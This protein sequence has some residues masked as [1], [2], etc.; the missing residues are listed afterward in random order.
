MAIFI[1]DA[2]TYV[3]DRF[4]GFGPNT[5]SIKPVHIANGLFRTILGCTYKTQSLNRFVFTNKANGIIPKGHE[6]DKIYNAL[7]EKDKIIVDEVSKEDLQRLRVLLKKVLNADD[8]VFNE[9]MES[10]SAAF[11][12]FVTK[13]PLPQQEGGEFIAEWLKKYHSPLHDCIKDTLMQ[14]DD[15]ISLVCSPLL[16]SDAQTHSTKRDY[17]KLIFLRQPSERM[18]N[19]QEGLLQA[20]QTL[21]GHLQ[22]HPNKFF[23]AR[24]SILFASFVLIRHLANLENYYVP[25]AEGKQQPFLMDFSKDE[26][27]PISRASAMTY[28][29]I[30]RSIARFFAWAFGEYLKGSYTVNELLGEPTPLYNRGSLSTRGKNTQALSEIWNIAK[31]EAQESTEPYTVFGQAIYDMMH[32]EAQ[33]NPIGYLRQ[34]GHRCGLLWPP[35]NLQ[36]T[37]QFLP[38]HDMLEML[39][40]GVVE[41]GQAINMPTLQELFWERY[42]IIVG[43]RSFDEQLL[44]NA[45]IYEADS[46]A[47]HQNRNRFAVSLSNLDFARLLADGVL[48]VEVEGYHAS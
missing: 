45:G 14:S 12:N 39:I 48:Q 15:I 1:E 29:L 2:R 4:I 43:G 41:P 46:D 32:I 37:K 28:T 35:R 47:L 23:R 36:P 42:G 24:T 6:L 33:G 38:Q 8:A 7:K 11:A 44:L 34:L 13:D 25:G 26:R 19:T 31:L 40:R 16:E 27:E 9:G 30:C 22:H 20:A 5:N 3:E 17:D 21:A 10:Y 18:I